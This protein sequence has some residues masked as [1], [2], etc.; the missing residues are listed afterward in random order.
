M[1]LNIR[2]KFYLSETQRSPETIKSDLK[3]A[4]FGVSL[5]WSH[6]YHACRQNDSGFE[7]LARQHK[8]L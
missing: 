4:K 5:G 1:S 7:S 8:T 2:L 6:A 3:R